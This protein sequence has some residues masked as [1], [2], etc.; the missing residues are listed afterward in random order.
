MVK[1]WELLEDIDLSRVLPK[2]TLWHAD[3]FPRH[4]SLLTH[5]LME[6][7]LGVEQV[8]R[9]TCAINT[10]SPRFTKRD[11]RLLVLSG[12]SS[13]STT[14][15]SSSSSASSPTSSPRKSSTP[16]PDY[17]ADV[18]LAESKRTITEFTNTHSKT[19]VTYSSGGRRRRGLEDFLQCWMI[20]PQVLGLNIAE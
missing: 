15:S 6:H 10:S 12:L 19:F 9:H 11:I 16:L 1:D 2:R 3:L 4:Q 14:S 17:F 20:I 8:F 18:V 7:A 5:R 13:T